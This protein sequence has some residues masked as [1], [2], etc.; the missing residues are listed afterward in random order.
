MQ[1]DAQPFLL[2]I[3]G[4]ADLGEHLENGL[5]L[6]R[7]EGPMPVCTRHVDQH[8]S[9][10]RRALIQIFP[11]EGVNLQA[12]LQRLR[13]PVAVAPRRLPPGSLAGE[14]SP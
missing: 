4:L 3:E 6:V 2:A 14:V 10:P 11:P 13:P 8:V 12:L 1:P 5:E 9:R 7:W